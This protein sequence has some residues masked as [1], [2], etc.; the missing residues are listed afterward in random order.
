[1]KIEGGCHCGKVRF[2]AEVPEAVEI[3]D[4]NCSICSRT[5]YLHIMVP[6][7]LFELEQG[8]DKLTSYRFG[9]GS[10]EHLFCSVCGVKSFYQP[11]SHPDAWSINAHC[12]DQPVELAVEKFDGQNWEQAAGRANR[13]QQ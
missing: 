9:T 8:A 2:E 5:G 11:R 7:A 12:L 3:L 13:V 6:H 4:C 1:M 10:A